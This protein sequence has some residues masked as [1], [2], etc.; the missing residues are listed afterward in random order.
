MAPS[1]AG[2]AAIPDSGL[3]FV[4][5]QTVLPQT[6]DPAWDYEATGSSEVI[7]NV[8]ETLVTYDGAS[9]TS[10]VPVL[11]TQVPTVANGGISGDGLTY[12]FNIRSGVHFHDGTLLTSDD[13][14]YS[15]KRVLVMNILESPAWMLAQ[16]LL[17]TYPGQGVAVSQS[18]V[19][20]AVVAVGPTV[21]FH[22]LRPTPAFLEILAFTVGSVVSQ[23][24]VDAHG[25][26]QSLTKNEW[27]NTHECGTGPYALQD[28]QPN[29]YIALERYDAYWR[30]PAPIQH[31]LLVSVPDDSTR[32]MMLSAGDVS[33][34]YS[35]AADLATYNAMADV[36]VISGLPILEIDFIGINEAI[37][38]HLDIGDIPTDFFADLHVRQAFVHSF[39]YDTYI[40]V[41]LQGRAVQPNGPIPSRI[42]G[43]DPTLPNCTFDLARAAAELRLAQNPVVPGSSYADTG[44]HIVL[45]YNAGN[46]ERQAMCQL[47]RD[48][49]EAL[50]QNTSAGVSGTITV[51]VVALDWPTYLDARGNRW[52]PLYFL[53]WLGDYPDPD[54]FAN[55]FCHENGA[56]PTIMGF[57]NHTLTN[58]VQLAA[59]ELNP[60][61]RAFYY[62]A[63]AR[64]CYDN[65]YYLFTSQPY[66]W[67]VERT[68]VEGYVYN[69]ALSGF[70]Y[71]DLDLDVVL[72]SA[73]TWSS[74]IGS[75]DHV[76]LTWNEPSILGSAP[77]QLYELYRGPSTSDLTYLTAVSDLSYTDYDVITGQT[78]YYAVRAVTGVGQGDPSDAQSV[79][80]QDVVPNAPTIG[81][82]TPAPTSVTVHWA[83][84]APNGGSPLT[85]YLVYYGTSPHPGVAH[86]PAEPS[87]A[88]ITVTGLAPSTPYYFNVVA[89]NTQGSSAPSDDVSASTGDIGPDAPTIGT[90]TPGLN[91]VTVTW[92][93]PAPN[94]GSAIT[95]YRVY[96]DTSPHPDSNY[97]VVGPTET[98]TTVTGLLSDTLYYF[99][100][101]AVNAHGTGPASEDASA[102]TG[103]IPPA[104]PSIGT[105]TPGLNNATVT[106][107][108]PAPNGGTALTGYLVF[109]GTAPHPSVDSI[110]AGPANTSASVPGLNASTTYYFNVVALN[111]AGGS[112]PSEDVSATTTDVVPNAPTIDFL[113]PEAT[114]INVTWIAPVPN[115]GSP[116]TEYRM[117]YGLDPN[118]SALSVSVGGDHYGWTIFG[119]DM[120][121]TYYVNVVAYN[122]A[123]ASPPSVDASATTRGLVPGA[124]TI[125]ALVTG[126]N[127]VSVTWEA[128]APNGGSPITGYR[129]FYG[130]APGP[131][132]VGSSLLVGN[133]DS[134]LVEGLA[135]GTSYYFNVVAINAAGNSTASEDQSATT[136]NTVPGAPG[137]EVF[138]HVNSLDA[139]WSP[140]APFGGSPITGYR[141]YYGLTTNS[142]SFASAGPADTNITLT[143]LSA[144]TIY[145]VRVVAVNAA[146]PGA[147]SDE[148]MVR[149]EDVAPNAPIIGSAIAGHNEVTVF[150]TA[151]ADNGGSPLT[152]FRVFYGMANHP[153]T[154]FV[155]AGPGNDSLTVGGLQTGTPYF[156]NVVAVNAAGNST[157][158]S[159]VWAA[160]Q[161]SEPPRGLTV[162]EGDGEILVNWTAPAD[163]SDHPVLGYQLVRTESP[164]GTGVTIELG[165]AV[166]GY[167]DRNLTLGLSYEY[168]LAAVTTV[169]W[170][171]DVRAGPARAVVFVEMS[172]EVSPSVAIGT[173]QITCSAVLTNGSG[174]PYTD[175]I[176]GFYYSRNGGAWTVIGTDT[177]SPNGTAVWNWQPAERSGSFLIRAVYAGSDSM[178]SASATT[179]MEMTEV[180]VSNLVS[181]TSTSTLSAL[182]VDKA[183]N[184]LSFTVEGATGTMGTAR[185]VVPT[186][187]VGD[188]SRIVVKVDGVAVQPVLSAVDGGWA[189]VIIYQH[190][191]HTVVVS[192]GALSGG[193]GVDS[194]LLIVVSLVAIVIVAA[195]LLLIVR[196]RKKKG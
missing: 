122:A 48:G 176:V 56:F 36:R 170:T 97:V 55:P 141:V 50:S 25:G 74:L 153:T 126:L 24:Y 111:A 166:V 138:L 156:F 147:P 54:D 57:A 106:W 10:M 65:A 100:V 95:S 80:T 132:E 9:L 194:S 127:N 70:H 152:G 18:E 58:L 195:A 2:V 112:P 85:G 178:R 172:M 136:L 158:S 7:E 42:F 53:G 123:G 116:I 157:A 181:V 13:V 118:P 8:Y 49:L 27:M 192:L 93:P 26:Y 29:Q 113:F 11:A 193:G 28:S 175:V 89:T 12:S 149:T 51:D 87:A 146:G 32:A 183:A 177:T 60:G 148:W 17:L 22:L 182:T 38:P 5:A 39:D 150:W 61:L 114:W 180:S 104:A 161:P 135:A 169:G 188:S 160:T 144:A 117:F 171:Q 190:S 20:A 71:Y 1:S 129:V 173:L 128:A 37:V 43:Y 16:C 62:S 134:A 76:D 120:A 131:A 59:V 107:S 165:G 98:N 108:A 82:A 31:V 119:L 69:A 41:V 4:N 109:Y 35:T 19:D 47:L 14:V 75:Y 125:T 34:A 184:E 92:T 155:F 67:Q 6:L 151:P 88:S 90:A 79:S 185:I 187:L 196:V 133:V 105:A 179:S 130:T 186:E 189:L 72:P 96:Y 154:T 15:I 44:F 139:I 174:A 159:D 52:L 30:G 142:S 168:S 163:A 115:G 83:A 3:T 110:A 137:M 63:I 64:S 40:D 21:T 191:A 77:I 78:Y 162:A 103:D 45:Y 101:R 73:P 66:T 91:E 140:P 167:V 102:T 81:A 84:P 23:E 68:W 124:P 121:T 145:Y 164:S 143:G 46:L 86:V 33:A 99:N 94:G